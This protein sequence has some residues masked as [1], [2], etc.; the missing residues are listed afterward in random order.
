[1][2][3]RTFVSNR[4]PLWLVLLLATFLACS[5]AACGT[6]APKAE[7]EQTESTE[8]QQEAANAEEDQDAQIRLVVSIDGWT[9]TERTV[10]VAVSGTTNTNESF[11][12]QLNVIPGQE[13]AVTYPAGNYTFAVAGATISDTTTIYK[14]ASAAYAWSE[15]VSKTVA[16]AVHKDTDAMAQIEAQR[17]AEEQARI[18]AE[19]QARQQAAAEEQARQQAAQAAQAQQVERTVHIT[20]TG[21]KYH[22]AGCQYLRKSDITV[23]LSEA[24]GRGLTPCSRCNP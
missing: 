3:T 12:G 24:Q 18:A 8:R 4:K 23:T 5:C 1:M 19:E 11:T 2:V 9:D 15:G 21:S 14:D 22:S 17:Q 16:L 6:N 10:P 7:N 13:K 20:E